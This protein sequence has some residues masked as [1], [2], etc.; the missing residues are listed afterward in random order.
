MVFWGYL[1]LLS[2]YEL[3]TTDYIYIYIYIYILSVCGSISKT[4]RRRDKIFSM[5]ACMYV[6][7][8]DA[9]LYR[10]VFV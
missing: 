6:I 3:G 9:I 4:H 8:F 1:R 10:Y 7:F 2:L 5:H